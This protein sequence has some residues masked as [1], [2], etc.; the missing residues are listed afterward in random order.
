MNALSSNMNDYDALG[1]LP[2]PVT[3]VSVFER[4]IE[5]MQSVSV[6]PNRYLWQDL[7]LRIL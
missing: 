7:L 2:K 3:P 1:E 5:E 6:V 4:S